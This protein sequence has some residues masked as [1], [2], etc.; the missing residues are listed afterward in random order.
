VIKRIDAKKEDV[1]PDTVNIEVEMRR[2]VVPRSNGT[3]EGASDHDAARLLAET[4]REVLQELE[5][6]LVLGSPGIIESTRLGSETIV[7]HWV[8][9]KKQG[10]YN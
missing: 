4:T 5:N 3:I 10:K 6:D 9:A 2:V 7:G 8:E 1:I